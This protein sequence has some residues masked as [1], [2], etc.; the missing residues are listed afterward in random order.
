MFVGVYSG[1]TCVAGSCAVDK[2]VTI[3]VSAAPAASAACHTA[4]WLPR[5]RTRALGVGKRGRID[6]WGVAV[7][8]GDLWRL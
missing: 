8:R 6:G 2:D 7:L 1:E 3:A 4:Q 5:E